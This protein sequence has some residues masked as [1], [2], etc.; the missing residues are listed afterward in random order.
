[1]PMKMTDPA[2]FLDDDNR[3][4]LYWGC[5]NKEPLYGVELDLKR[6]F[7][8]IGEFT[9]TI[10]PNPK[11][12]GWE[13]DGDY[14]QLD[15][16]P[17]IEG[18][19]M[20]KINGIYYLQYAAP[21]TQYRSYCDAVYTSKKPLGP[22]TLA[23]HNPFS[24][25]IGGFAG[26]AGHGNTF[27]DKYE[28]YWHIA[29]MSISIHH[30]FERRLGLFPTFVDKDGLLHTN[31]AWGDFPMHI[32]QKQ[33]S[34][35][36]DVF[37]DYMLLSYKKKAITSTSTQGYEPA[38]ALDEDIRS[39]W[40]AKTGESG[41][42]FMVDLGVACKVKAIQ[43]NYFDVNSNTYDRDSLDYYQYLVEYSTDGET[44]KIYSDKRNSKD[45]LSHI[46]LVS[47]KLIKAR[48][49]RITNFKVPSGKF[50]LSDFRVFGYKKGISS[51]IP[52][53]V[54][55]IRN[56]ND[57]RK[58]VIK[59]KPVYGATG[60]NITYGFAPDKLYHNHYI[61]GVDT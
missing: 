46:F 57:K 20:N 5:S 4:Y 51:G 15:S 29:T 27:K 38:K 44:W 14:N 48:Y 40:A 19:W 35:I 13:G 61:F 21:G 54:S 36:E 10:F 47:D 55:A 33:I 24:L 22:F 53:N 7:E 1:M 45:A 58:V 37:T 18:S 6:N 42:W 60:Y 39:A 59:W 11:V 41:E 52:E 2:L 23:E 9:K 25:K 49:F 12:L 32:P 31:T 17:W 30:N 56:S 28:N 16:A 43:I 8:P 34:T 50:A 26:G 3:L